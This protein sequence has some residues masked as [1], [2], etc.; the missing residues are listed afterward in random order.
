MRK[1]DRKKIDEIMAGMQC[2]KDFRCSEDGFEKLCKAGDCG[3]DKLLECLEV[4]P[5]DCSFALQFG[6]GHFCT[7]PLRVYLA[8]ELGK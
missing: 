5:G 1:E 3:L 8:K 2:P 4:K 7:C 6:Y